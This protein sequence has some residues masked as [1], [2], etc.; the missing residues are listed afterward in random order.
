[1]QIDEVRYAEDLDPLGLTWI[2]LGLKDVLYDPKS[3]TVYTPNTNQSSR[4]DQ[5]EVGIRGSEDRGNDKHDKY[6]RIITNNYSNT[7]KQCVFLI[8]KY[9]Q[10]EKTNE[11]KETREAESRETKGAKR[12]TVKNF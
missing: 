3:R 7:P 8:K 9:K 12:I 6:R 4:L 10:K 2:K 5:S 11:P 1:M